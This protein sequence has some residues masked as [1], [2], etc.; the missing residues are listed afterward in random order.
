M[1]PR[2]SPSLA[3]VDYFFNIQLNMNKPFRIRTSSSIV[4]SFLSSGV[5]TNYQRV[6]VNSPSVV[7]F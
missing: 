2:P 3:D 1:Y 4:H 5:D 6:D 7:K